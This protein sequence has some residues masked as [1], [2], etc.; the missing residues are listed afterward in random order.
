MLTWLDI[1]H[2]DNRDVAGAVAVIEAARA[3][4]TPYL[5]G[6]TTTIF[7]A[8]LRHGWDG[9]R[10]LAALARDE[11]DR[12]IGVLEVWLPHWDNAHLGA[13]EVTV[14]PVVRRQGVGRQL[15]DAGV[16][17]V[18]AEGRTLV[19]SEC[20]DATA[21]VDFLKAMGLDRA[22][23]AVH[24]RQDLVTV[25]WA[26]LDAEYAAA[27]SHAEGYELVRIAG[28]TPDDLMTGVAQMTAAINDAPI[29]DLDIEDEVFSPERIR[30]FET[31]Q[32]ARGHRF[33]RVVARERSSGVLAGHTMVGVDSERP[34]HAGQH[35][36]S[37]LRAHRGHRLGL[38]LKIDMLR[39]LAEVEPQ[40][41][42]LDTQNA[43]SN[44][45]MIQVNEVLGYH[46]LGI[47]FEWQRH[48]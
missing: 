44:A 39:W 6:V 9:D 20:F 47:T 28:P 14:D 31:A 4:D 8:R 36:T 34:W 17:R 7:A 26:R 5:L 16:A 29:G 43:A 18:R 15:F 35:D 33:Y 2:L 45:H 46:L 19:L 22:L 30:A 21:G 38:L 37:V 25:D 27:E 11:R 13:V 41:R 12:V 40:L 24:R 32:L 3:V 23:E 1:E 42:I 10:I 48:L